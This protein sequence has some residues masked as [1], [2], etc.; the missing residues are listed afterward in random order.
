MCNPGY[1][2]N[3]KLLLP[4]GDWKIELPVDSFYEFINKPQENKQGFEDLVKS[5][6][7]GGLL[8]QQPTLIGTKDAITKSIEYLDGARAPIPQSTFDEIGNKIMS[9]LGVPMDMI[10]TGPSNSSAL[11]NTSTNMS[12][13]MQEA[14]RSEMRILKEKND[15]YLEV[16]QVQAESLKTKDIEI[17]KLKEALNNALNSQ[18]D[19]ITGQAEQVPPAKPTTSDLLEDAG[20]MFGYGRQ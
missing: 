7:E 8:S 6:A 19:N 16:I 3:D 1:I 15:N 11:K 10:S 20:K 13:A 9:S 17:A 5:L 14:M 18:L 12:D 4:K 2:D